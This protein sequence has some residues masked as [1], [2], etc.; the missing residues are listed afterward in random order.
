MPRPNK[1]RNICGLPRTNRFGPNSSQESMLETI[2]LTIDEYE[3]IRLIDFEG[4]TQEEAATQMT[5]ART[6]VQRIY[7]E[8]RKKIADALVNGKQLI[9]SGGSYVLC[10]PNSNR[11][12]RPQRLRQHRCWQE[13]G[14][15]K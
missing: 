9:I 14:E 1:P 10:D 11:C 4:Y 3:C 6:T 7:E 12:G 5:V 13:K 2:P 15:L 8:A